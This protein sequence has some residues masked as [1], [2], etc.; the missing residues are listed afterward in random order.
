[1]KKDQNKENKKD[2]KKKSGSGVL[3]GYKKTLDNKIAIFNNI[4][5]NNGNVT[6]YYVLHPYNYAVMDLASAE[7]HVN[8]LYTAIN[9]LYSNMGEVKMS[10]FSL[11]SMVSREETIQQI[12]KTVRMYKKDYTG[13]P[14]EYRQYI[15]HIARDFTILAINIEAKDSVD[16]ENQSALKIIKDAFDTFVKDNFSTTTVTIDEEALNIQNTRIKNSLQRYAVPASTKLVM[17]IYVNSLFPS[18]DLIYND[19]MLTHNSAILSGIQQ[20]IIPHL[21]WFEMSNSGI[22]AFGGTPRV[23][24]GCVLTILEFPESIYSENF[25]I[26]MPGMH[27]NMHLLPKDKAILKFKR[28]RADAKQEEEEA[29]NAATDDSDVDESVDLV[30]RALYS[31][32]QGRI[33]SEVDANILVTAKTKEELDQ[34]KKHIISVLSDVN[35]VCTIAGNQAKTYVNSFIKNKP[36]DG[37]YHVM[38]LQYALSFQIDNGINCGEADSKFSAPVIGLG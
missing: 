3:I 22:V 9:T 33:V 14:E 28:M 2:K 38:D 23:T 37:Y 7:R 35:I 32:R 26:A 16:I 11:R 20:E 21:G 25:N 17:N 6:A 29:V 8:R 15:K 34:K 12:V 18:Y 31:I 24:Y 19:Y 10:M 4:L 36:L 30:Q 1:M 27:V 13:F 5:I